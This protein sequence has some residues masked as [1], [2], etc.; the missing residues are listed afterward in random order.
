[1]FFAIAGHNLTIV[2]TDAAYLKPF[3][4]SHIVI[5]PGQTMDVLVRANQSFG[6]YYM[7]A[8]QY[9]TDKAIFTEYDKVNVTAILQYSGDYSPPSSPY[10]PTLPAYA[11]YNAAISFRNNLRSLVPQDVPKNITTCMFITAA[12]N[13]NLFN[14]SGD[15]KI[16]LATSLN[17]ISFVNPWVDVLQAYYYNI[18]G[19]YTQDFPDKPPT[20][21]D[22]VADN[23]G[24][25]T[26]K[27]LMGTKVKVLEYG[28]QV[29][30][31]FQ[32]ANVLNASEDHP[33]HLHGHSF[34]MVGAG[35]GNFDFDEDPK[36]YNL[37]DPPYVNTATLPR[38]GWL[39]VR[40]YATN[41][42]V[43]LWHCHLER[44]YSW[45]MSTVLIVKNGGTPETTMREPPLNMPVCEPP[46]IIEPIKSKYSP[47]EAEN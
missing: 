32:S 19:F 34:Y 1:M 35:G 36:T 39:A 12:Q 25:N 47:K 42:G 33:M 26:T 46:P 4:S 44:H 5:G 29:E 31:V 13:E 7:A 18:S 10:C 40:F 21:Y 2:G 24:I 27:S 30:M 17:N 23:L 11:D 20:F 43:W 38:D 41:P 37:V 15:V 28:E 8:R 9:Y 14:D 6:H 45:G 3:I 22:F 16:S